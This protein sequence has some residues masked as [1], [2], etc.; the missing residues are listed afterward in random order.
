[1]TLIKEFN[2][3]YPN[4]CVNVQRIMV[5]EPG[6]EVFKATAILDIEHPERIYTSYA[7]TTWNLE[8]AQDRAIKLVLKLVL[9]K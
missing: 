7:K 4:G 5:E 8:A 2:K 3:N 6:V 9:S 1:M